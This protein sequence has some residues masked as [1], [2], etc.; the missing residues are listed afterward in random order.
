[1][2]QRALKNGA[3]LSLAMLFT[4]MAQADNRSISITNTQ[5]LSFGSFSADKGGTV[6]ISATGMRTA[7]GAVTLLSSDPGQAAQFAITTNR[8][9]LSYNVTLPTNAK[10]TGPGSAMLLSQLTTNPFTDSC[11]TGKRGQQILA[12]GGTLAVENS[13]TAGN[14]STT[15]SMTVDLQ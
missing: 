11:N 1:M 10:L 6:T 5:G 13:Q 14:Y 15:F 8:A 9:N 12:V 7:S 3:F 4:A 2:K